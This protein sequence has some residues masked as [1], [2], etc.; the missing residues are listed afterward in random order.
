MSKNKTK[1]MDSETINTAAN[2]LLVKGHSESGITWA[3]AFDFAEE[4]DTS[5]MKSLSGAEWLKLDDFGTYTFAFM[6]MDKAQTDDGEINVVKLADKEGKEFI[7]SLAVL[8]STC[9]KLTQIPSFIKIVYAGN[10]KGANGTYK[11]LKIY[12]L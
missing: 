8:L 12:S 6:G 10:R 7:S 5:K 1:T 2:E 4:Q 11:D 3:E 9:Q